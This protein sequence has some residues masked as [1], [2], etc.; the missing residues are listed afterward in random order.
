MIGIS[1]RR[2]TKFEKKI[3]FV[4]DDRITA[5]VYKEKMQ[6]IALYCVMMLKLAVMYN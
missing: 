3:A 5:G 2:I 1:W 4:W 6:N